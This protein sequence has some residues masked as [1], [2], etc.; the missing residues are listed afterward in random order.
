MFG[1]N[2]Y[3][4]GYTLLDNNK[5]SFG[6]F[7]STRRICEEDY[8]L[9]FMLKLLATDLIKKIGRNFIFFKSTE[10]GRD[11]ILAER[12]LTPPRASRTYIGEGV[13]TIYPLVESES[14]INNSSLF[15][16]ANIVELTGCN[17][18]SFLYGTFSDD[19]AYMR[20]G[21]SGD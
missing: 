2:V 9:L 18:H 19:E 8:D 3:V 17:I 7:H 5:I 1:C 15:V 12:E 16:S 6:D 13:Y 20:F 21:I 4:M 14:D 11:L 10:L